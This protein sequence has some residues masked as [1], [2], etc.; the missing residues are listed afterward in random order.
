[1]G[2]LNYRVDVFKENSVVLKTALRQLQKEMRDEY[3]GNA[4]VVEDLKE[5]RYID[6][7]GRE[8]G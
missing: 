2:E 1:M 7:E 8:H 5:G 4:K 3:P 6:G